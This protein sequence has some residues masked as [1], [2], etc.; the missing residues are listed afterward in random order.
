MRKALD[1]F[2]GAGG[3][4]DGLLAAGFDR[5]VGI[6]NDIGCAA[7]YPGDF[8]IGD[9]LR[10]PVELS[11]FDFIWASPP[12]QAYSTSSRNNKKRITKHP[13]LVPATQELLAG[14]PFTCIENVVGAPIRQDLV[15]YGWMVGLPRIQNRRHFELSWFVLQPDMVKPPRH[16]WKDYG[17]YGLISVT[18]SGSCRAH[19][20]P[21]RR[22][23][24]KPTATRKE[25]HEVKGIFPLNRMTNQQVANAVPPAYAEYIGRVV[26]PLIGG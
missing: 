17:T 4:A 1:L 5:V 7:S 16:A 14:H 26:L 10:P 11:D 9:A 20:E 8:I 24:L 15:L 6:D 25:M 23:G 21:R 19:T 18:A 3:T 22:I 2:C 12:C 13:D